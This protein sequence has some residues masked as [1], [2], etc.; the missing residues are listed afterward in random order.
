MA[1]LLICKDKKNSLK[2]RLSV[3]NEHLNYIKKFEKKLIL[4][5]P[6]LDKTEKSR[7]SII[8]LDFDNLN[9]VNVFIKNDPYSKI[10]LFDKIII[11]KFKK[12]F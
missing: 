2:K 1:Y 5:G 10:K 6:I 7:G 3:R 12:V 11:H 9:D 4:A 8:V